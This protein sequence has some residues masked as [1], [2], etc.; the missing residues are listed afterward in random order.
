MNFIFIL[1]ENKSEKKGLLK[2]NYDVVSRQINI[3]NKI[4]LY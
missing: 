4:F 2:R 3:E 1:G